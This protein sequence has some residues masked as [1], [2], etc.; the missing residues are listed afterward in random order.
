MN[1]IIIEEKEVAKIREYEVEHWFENFIFNEFELIAKI[2][3][4]KIIYKVFIN[5]DVHKVYYRMINPRSYQDCEFSFT[6]KEDGGVTFVESP[7]GDF[8]KMFTEQLVNKFGKIKNND[9]LFELLLQYFVMEANF[10][11]SA[12]QYIMNESYKRTKQIKEV[13]RRNNVEPKSN[14]ENNRSGKTQVQF[15]LNDIVEYVS[16]NRRKF[17]ITCECWG[18]RGHFRHYKNGNI[19]WIPSY[20]KGKKR[21][22]NSVVQNK[23]YKI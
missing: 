4:G 7:S 20:E 6:T 9:E 10:I 1:T 5:G 19:V 18:V 11:T 22:T 2:E 15:L 23:I 16:H 12:K 3:S 8:V 21:N 14:R 13:S 17:N